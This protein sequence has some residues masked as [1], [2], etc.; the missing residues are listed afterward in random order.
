MADMKV[1]VSNIWKPVKSPWVKAG[2]V[3]KVVKE[4]LVKV[5]GVWKHT[6]DFPRTVNIGDAYYDGGGTGF[7]YTKGVAGTIDHDE[8]LGKSISFL[9][10]HVPT[11]GMDKIGLRLDAPLDSSVRS[12]NLT[13]I[14]TDGLQTS[15]ILS[16]VSSSLYEV[17]PAATFNTIIKNAW[18]Q[19]KPVKIILSAIY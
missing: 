17:S 19:H 6:Y 1:K 5:G 3:W 16:R 10:L 4:V 7:G 9:G 18:V 13:C 8:F 12:V 11:I 14:N 15:R 2:N